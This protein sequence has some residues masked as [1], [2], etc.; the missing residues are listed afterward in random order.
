MVESQEGLPP[1][2]LHPI[3]RTDRVTSGLTLCCTSPTV[4]RAFHK[5]LVDGSVDKL[6]LARVV[7][8]FPA[9]H[10]ESETCRNCAESTRM[11]GTLSWCD[12]GEF[13]M[14]DAPVFTLDSSSGLR[15]VDPAGKQSQSRF[16]RLAYDPVQNMSLLACFPITGRNHQLRVHLQWL[17]YPI[18][19][20]VQYGGGQSR[21]L[22]PALLGDEVVEAM[23]RAMK[24]ST[25]SEKRMGSLTPEDVSAAQRACPCCRDGTAKGIRQSF[26]PAQLLVEGHSI[27]LHAWRYRARFFPKGVPRQDAVDTPV[28]LAELEFKVE[29]PAWAEA[30]VLRSAD[31]LR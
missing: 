28:L 27:N 19:D 8:Q 6:Y 12:V 14:V 29:P 16:R 18:V 15:S 23:V 22:Q 9:S 17:G 26:T 24:A 4:S 3:H 20:D 7:G 2:S 10:T 13:L 1:Q 5:C 25:L 21:Q 31:W 30:D 11:F